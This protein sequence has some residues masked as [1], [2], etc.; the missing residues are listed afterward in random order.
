M[1]RV[2]RSAPLAALHV[3][4]EPDGLLLEP[5][6]AALRWAARH[7]VSDAD[8]H[9][10]ASH[11][12]SPEAPARVTLGLG[13]PAQQIDCHRIELAEGQWLF[14]LAPPPEPAGD[15]IPQQS[16]A[17]RTQ[18]VAEIMG[19]GFWTRDLDTGIGAWD[20]QMYRIHRRSP[21]LGPPGNDEWITQYVHPDDRQR[22]IDM[23]R[24]ATVAWLP[25]VDVIFRA[26]DENGRPRWVH[27]WTRRVLRDG[28]RLAFGMH[29]DVTDRE[30]ERSV[31][32]RERARMQFAVEAAALG[33]WERSADGKRSYWNE[34]MYRL[35]D[36]D[37]ADP[38]PIDELAAAV[39]HPQDL[40]RLEVMSRQH[41]V[42]G[43]PYRFEFR[44]RAADGRWRWLGTRGSALRDVHGRLV[45][46]A[47]INIDI[48]DR[49]Q[50]D[51]LRLLNERA[52]QASRDKST[53][54]ARVS[55]ELRTP[56]NAVLGFTQLLSD[57]P[58]SPPSPTQLARLQ[59][60]TDAG[61]QMMTLVDE[62]LDLA[63]QDGAA[64]A[65]PMPPAPTVLGPLRVLCVEDN[66]VNL[67]LVRELL[68]QRPGV[69]LFEAVDGRSGIEAALADPPDLLL[70][71]LQLPDMPGLQVLQRLRGEPS[72]AG[73]RF[74]ALSADAMPAHIAKA[75]SQGFDDY[76][77]KP[78]DF[79]QFLAGIDRLTAGR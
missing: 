60:I 67:L 10:L 41:L 47:G 6:E 13:S 5:N 24:Q 68:A 22:A 62:L 63:R 39:A 37:P 59:C 52:Q 19:V 44:V 32:E 70:L 54:L 17:D 33:I 1:E 16:L 48:T 64:P 12:L 76:W 18:L 4:A 25:S 69:R 38:R 36:L 9:V 14:W 65:T 57:D 8:W 61:R 55:H 40:A 49:K 51:E 3:R 20:E 2:W 73:C 35:R 28:R 21:A 79:A 23:R 31:L 72:L 45:G 11:Q 26:C 58:V 30:L 50:A 15:A 7:A 46:L 42:D 34:T 75:L 78:I 71:D 56:M 53:F 43:T 77:T 29:V 66:P 74:V 27:S